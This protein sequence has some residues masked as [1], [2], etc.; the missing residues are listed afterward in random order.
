MT[1]EGRM[2]TIEANYA[3]LQKSIDDIKEN[4]LKTIYN[5]LSG[6]ELKLNARPTWLI[7]III[8]ALCSLVVGLIISGVR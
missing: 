4:H 7:T 2:A 6:I 8:T 1:I 5:R 3:N